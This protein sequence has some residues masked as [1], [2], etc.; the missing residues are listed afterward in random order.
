MVY[1][2]G[3]DIGSAFSKAVLLAN[4][5]VVS[6][7]IIPSVGSYEAVADEVAKGALARANLS[8]ADRRNPFTAS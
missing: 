7:H 3:V 8:F 4:N 6:F 1:V 2:A 5:D